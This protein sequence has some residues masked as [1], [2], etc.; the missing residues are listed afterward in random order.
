MNRTLTT[1]G[2]TFVAT[3]L[4]LAVNLGANRVSAAEGRSWNG[5]PA[6][7]PVSRRQATGGAVDVDMHG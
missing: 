7:V 1:F 6:R 2:L 5:R 4:M 3:V